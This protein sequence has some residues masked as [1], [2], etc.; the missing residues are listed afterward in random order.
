MKI[1]QK[2]LTNHL[3]WAFI[4][5]YV[6]FILGN[7]ISLVPGY[8][9]YS[10]VNH[11]F[12]LDLDTFFNE[13]GIEVFFFPSV[14]GIIGGFLGFIGV[15]LAYVYNNDH[16]IYRNGEE[17]GSA[18]FATADEIEKFAEPLEGKENENTIWTESARMAISN[19]NLDF[20]YKKN[21][22][23][24]IIGGPGSGKTFN[25]LKP[26]I[27]QMNSSFLV[28]DPKGLMVKETGA[29][30]K[31]NDF[32][33]KVFDLFRLLNS[34]SFN[35]FRYIK[36][37]LDIDRVL[38]A[39]IEGTKKGEERGEDFWQ[40]AEELLIRSFI[41]YLWFDGKDNGYLPHLGMLADMLRLTERKD[42]NVKSPV[43]EW[44]EE[45]NRKHPDNYAYK[46]WTLF[47]DLFTSETRTS[48]LAIA[49]S[50]YSIF[51]HEQVVDMV[52]EDT[53]DIE[54]WNVEKTAIFI[55]IPENNSSYNFLAAI[56][57]ATAL[58]VLSRKADEILGGD[59]IL[60]E[61][62]SLRH[63]R[64]YFDEFGNIGKI[65]NIDKAMATLR[66]RN[67]S[68]ILFLQALDQLK[69]MYKYGWATI[70]NTCDTVLFLGGDEAETTKYLSQRAGKQT[71]SI[72]KSSV[73]KGKN[74]SSSENRDTMGRDLL[75]PDEVGRLQ[76]ND[77]LLFISGQH[78]F[79]D[80][81]FN[82]SHH[83]NAHLL[84]NGPTDANWYRYRIYRS[85]EEE[86][87]D[88]VKKED[89]VDHGTI[90]DEAA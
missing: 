10:K 85:E 87:L 45:Q 61:G 32:E 30:L 6:G 13:V 8:D 75:M 67:M 52:R 59:L 70:L 18:R 77:C 28:I 76:G 86:L 50:R 31:E 21:K 22:N 4:L 58:E 82:V 83:E 54:S 16:G 5:F 35:V 60:P 79:K 12:S 43:E 71:I 66:S 46:Q 27:M 3:I 78:V 69:K 80:K 20:A 84:A 65:P 29:M 51:D 63:F 2:N 14:M 25:F 42:K 62:K 9:L 56:L 15:M 41:A 34:H 38:E 44:F 39:I 17:H 89:I 24:T 37:E 33:I 26:N 72:R 1:Y 48:V 88:K 53:M 90:Y 57:V 81:K 40:Q 64:I 74:G 55:T 49:A 36:T 68:I 19:D 23:G 47:N 73:S 11:L 7:F